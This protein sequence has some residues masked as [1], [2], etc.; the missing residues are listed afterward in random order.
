MRFPFEISGKG[1]NTGTGE[2]LIDEEDDGEG[3]LTDGD[4]YDLRS[5][6]PSMFKGSKGGSGKRSSGRGL[7]LRADEATDGLRRTGLR[8]CLSVS[9]RS[10]I[11]PNPPK[12]SS[13][14]MSSGAEPSLSAASSCLLRDI[15]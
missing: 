6:T 10:G 9:R 11:S 8:L 13:E 2:R 7:R 4:R 1:G 5:S 14:N 3:G 15:D 12:P